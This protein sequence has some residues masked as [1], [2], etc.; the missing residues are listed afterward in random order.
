MTDDQKG[1]FLDA[2]RQGRSRLLAAR[3]VGMTPEEAAH[4][5]WL[6]LDFAAAVA[7]AEAEATDEVRSALHEAAVSGNVAAQK[8]WLESG[9]QPPRDLVANRVMTPGEVAS[10]LGVPLRRVRY[11]TDTGQLVASARTAGGHR[12]YTVQD[13]ER[14]EHPEGPV[15]DTEDVAGDFDEWRSGYA[16]AQEARAAAQAADSYWRA[17]QREHRQ[18]LDEGEVFQRDVVQAMVLSVADAID[19]CMGQGLAV[20][21]AGVTVGETEISEL[22]DLL[23]S[24]IEARWRLHGVPI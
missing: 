24:E 3:D 2:L 6:S 19:S 16:T 5:I 9:N 18:R 8:L 14:Y 1:A 23:K 11:L 12:R 15:P 13:V 22:M 20:A 10:R 4:F 7:E 17:K 21:W